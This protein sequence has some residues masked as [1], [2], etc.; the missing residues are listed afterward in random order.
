MIRVV[1]K[2]IYFLVC[3]ILFL[4]LSVY[5]FPK[6]QLLCYMDS[7]LH[8]YY[9]SFDSKKIED[10]GFNLILINTAIKYDNLTVLTAKEITF[11]ITFF[12]N[13]VIVKDIYLNNIASDILPEKID[14]AT[15]YWNILQGYTLKIYAKGDIGKIEGNID[16]FHRK[17]VLFLKPTKQSKSRYSN[18]LKVMKKEAKGYKY[19]KSF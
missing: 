11:F 5:L 16:L 17:I 4:E 14:F 1:K 3:V 10:D 12:S 6:K 7:K 9:I 2:V 18:L 15:L 19:V 8:S 13:K